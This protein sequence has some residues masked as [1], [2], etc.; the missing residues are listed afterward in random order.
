MFSALR[1]WRDFLNE[2]SELSESQGDRERIV[3]GSRDGA[4]DLGLAGSDGA[5]RKDPIDDSSVIQERVWRCCWHVLIR[6]SVLKVRAAR[7]VGGSRAPGPIEGEVASQQNRRVRVVS[8][9]IVQGLIKL[10]AA[11]RII[12]FAFQVQIIGDECFPRD[13]GIADQRQTSSDSFLKRLDF[14]KEPVRAPEIGLSLKPYEA[15]I[16]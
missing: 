9:G 13:V 6:K 12:A 15:R 16:Q 14:R 10:G 7:R 3:V 1:R 2:A 8:P 11:Q 4:M 5:A